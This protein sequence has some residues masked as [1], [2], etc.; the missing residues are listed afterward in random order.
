[1]RGILLRVTVLLVASVPATLAGAQSLV[2]RAIPPC[3]IVDTRLAAGGKLEAGVARSFW[4][5]DGPGHDFVGQGGTAAGCGV[6]GFAGDP[7]QAQVGAVLFNVVAV[8]PEGA[9]NL[10]AW[11]PGESVPNASILNYAQVP[12]LNIANGI[13]V[14]VRR[15]S[16]LKGEKDL[17]V[18][19][20]TSRVHLVVD[21]VGYFELSP[22][23]GANVSLYSTDGSE[24][25][26]NV[27]Q[28]GHPTL[29][30]NP[31]FRLGR[32]VQAGDGSPEF[33]VLYHGDDVP[34]SV[35][36]QEWPVLEF[37]AKGIVAS[38][39]PPEV[40]GG[41]GSHF[42]GFIR[43]KEQPLFR[44]NSFPEMQLEM[45]EGG[46]ACTDVAL[47]R[48]VN[49]FDVVSRAACGG[50]EILQVRLAYGEVYARMGF[51]QAGLGGEAL[52]VIRGAVAAGGTA[53]TGSGFTSM[54]TGTGQY[55]INFSSPFTGFPVVSITPIGAGARLA[56]VAG[57]GSSLLMVQ[58]WL[59]D[60]TAADMPFF[61][62]ATG[63][64]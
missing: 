42:E 22:A 26:L 9:G 43:G 17:W 30:M 18:R 61:F 6:P 31:E 33:R 23:F 51:R 62:T 45:G 35:P 38:V 37:D 32:L 13:P 15:R 53:T 52:K 5:V 57:Y 27:R 40:G 29:P 64:P 39:K 41:R 25:A 34:S 10:R 3:R 14:G 36:G 60:G 59:P 58:T 56:N 2:Y 16:D 19:A 12:G 63:V 54:R 7:P 49:G 44:L 1:M 21:V 28:A 11:A 48:D 4:A 50:G 46:S 55:Q 47:R 20:D 24:R 8:Q